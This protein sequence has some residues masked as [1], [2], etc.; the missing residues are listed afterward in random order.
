MVPL[1]RHEAEG[2]ELPRSLCCIGEST[3]SHRACALVDRT[4]IGGLY[5]CVAAYDLRFS[6]EGQ[7]AIG[8]RD[9]FNNKDD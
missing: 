1:R 8:E 2:V 6:M 3:G 4:P 7:G 9:T 5:K